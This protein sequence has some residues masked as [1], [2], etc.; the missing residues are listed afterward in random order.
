MTLNEFIIRYGVDMT[1]VVA[2]AYEEDG[3]IHDMAE[4]WETAQNLALSS[5]YRVEAIRGD[6]HLTREDIQD[7]VDHERHL[8]RDCYG[9]EPYPA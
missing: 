7:M 3:G 4:N 9:I 6:G 1:K 2:I 8:Y 5:G